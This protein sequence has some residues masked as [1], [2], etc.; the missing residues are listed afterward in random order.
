MNK[1]NIFP[2]KNTK[3]ISQLPE[4]TPKPKYEKK[5]ENTNRLKNV[6]ISG[7]LEY[8]V[9]QLFPFKQLFPV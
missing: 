6:R 9:E 8:P 2:I 4:G 3:Y 1:N 7:F 5:Y